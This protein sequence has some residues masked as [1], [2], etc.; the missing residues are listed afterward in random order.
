MLEMI[1]VL[2]YKMG[3]KGLSF[4]LQIEVTF[5]MLKEQHHSE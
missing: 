2:Y 4:H 5:L 3:K 1:E